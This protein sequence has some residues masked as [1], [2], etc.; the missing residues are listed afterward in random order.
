MPNSKKSNITFVSNRS[1]QRRHIPLMAL[2][3]M[4]YFAGHNKNSLGHRDKN[5]FASLISKSFL[6]YSKHMMTFNVQ[7]LKILESWSA[8][9]CRSP[10]HSLTWRSC[11]SWIFCRLSAWIL[12]PRQSTPSPRFCTSRCLGPAWS[13]CMIHSQCPSLCTA[14][15][16]KVKT[17]LFKLRDRMNI[18]RAIDH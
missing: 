14:R 18:K 8:K 10:F 16:Q 2:W 1:D 15:R 3:K 13:S 11:L 17:V 9:C 7:K 5:S 4:L 12:P 6:Q